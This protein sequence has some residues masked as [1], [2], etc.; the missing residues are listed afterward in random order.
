MHQMTHFF[1]SFY[2]R[3]VR[4][5]EIAIAFTAMAISID[6]RA[7]D[8]KRVVSVIAQILERSETTGGS[9]AKF[10]TLHHL[11]KCFSEVSGSSSQPHKDGLGP[12]KVIIVLG[13]CSGCFHPVHEIRGS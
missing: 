1:Q 3:F 10:I 2:V 12:P 13:G 5:F 6:C 7:F 8:R 9:V 11:L 4:R